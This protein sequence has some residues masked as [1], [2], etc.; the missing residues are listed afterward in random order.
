[1]TT[2]LLKPPERAA[3]VVVG[4]LLALL[5]VST[6]LNVPGRPPQMGEPVFLFA[7]KTI[8]VEV[9]GAVSHGGLYEMAAGSTVGD[10]L[11]EAVVCD[12]CDLRGLDLG[13]KLRNHQ[14][15]DIPSMEW[16]VVEVW[17]EGVCPEKIRLPKGSTVGALLKEA[18]LDPDAALWRL[19]KR[20]PLSDGDRIEIRKKRPKRI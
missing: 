8:E 2:K 19:R 4:G 13:A 11:E 1:M 16:I 9:E 15:I 6:L 10:L 17:G 14:R 20:E 7:P 5:I 18:Q 12:R 3:I